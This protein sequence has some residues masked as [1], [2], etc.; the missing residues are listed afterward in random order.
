MLSPL[1]GLIV[2]GCPPHGASQPKKN[3]SK[4]HA[5]TVGSMQ[6]KTPL[7]YIAQPPKYFIFCS[8]TPTL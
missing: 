5:R 8:V 1:G 3:H 7:D 4:V 2:V 6:L